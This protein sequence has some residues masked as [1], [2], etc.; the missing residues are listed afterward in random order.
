MPPALPLAGA[1]ED[2][3]QASE[4]S[5]VSVT[6]GQAREPFL[7]LLRARRWPGAADRQS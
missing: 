1:W 5:P 6:R 2:L 7:G 4:A 3:G